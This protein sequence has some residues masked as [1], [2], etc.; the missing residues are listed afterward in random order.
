MLSAM[1]ELFTVKE[2]TIKGA[3][4]LSEPFQVGAGMVVSIITPNKWTAADLT[5]LSSPIEGMEWNS[6]FDAVGNELT[7][8]C[9]ADREIR[10]MPALN[11]SGWVRLRSGTTAAPVKQEAARKML[12]VIQGL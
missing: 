8:K 10:L 7:V 5:F 6:V 3:K 9:A 12:V 4:G 2:V 11:R 1:A